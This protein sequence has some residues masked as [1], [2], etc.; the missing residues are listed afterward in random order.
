[1]GLSFFI[2]FIAKIMVANTTMKTLPMATAKLPK[3]MKNFSPSPAPFATWKIRKVVS[4]DT[5]MPRL[6]PVTPYMMLS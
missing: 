5:G 4:I 1:M 6:R 2:L 3:G